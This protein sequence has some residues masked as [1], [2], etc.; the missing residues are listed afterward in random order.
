MNISRISYALSSALVLIVLILVIVSNA[1]PTPALAKNSATPVIIDSLNAKTEVFVNES[2]ADKI[3][4]FGESFIGTP[5][6]A[7][8]KTP[9]GFDCSGFTHYVFAKF[10]I[11]LSPASKEQIFAGEQVNLSDVRKGDL[12][13]FTGTNRSIRQPGHVGIVITAKGEKPVKFVHSSSNGGVKISQVDSTTYA[14]RLLQV[15]RLIQ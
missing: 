15:R 2:L 10:G 3:I 11:E 13:I 7:T 12:L 1:I 14:L 5:Y 4:A 6:Y 9:R 8:G